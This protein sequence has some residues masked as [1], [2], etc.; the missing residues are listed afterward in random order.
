MYSF[1]IQGP[2][3]VDKNPS[4]HL[5]TNSAKPVDETPPQKKEVKRAD[6]TKPAPRPA[7]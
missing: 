7:E 5:T 4:A 2:G 1:L 6:R 3:V